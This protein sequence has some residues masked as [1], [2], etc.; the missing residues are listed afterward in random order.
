MTFTG[1]ISDIN[2]ALGTVTYKPDAN[3]NGTDAITLAVNDQGNTGSGGALSDSD[4]ANITVTAVNDAPTIS[5]IGDQ[6]IAEDGTTGALAFSVSD[7][8]TAAG[9]LTVTASSSNTTI[10]P[11][12]NLTLVDLGSGNWTIEASPALNQNGGPVTVTVDDGT[13]TTDETFDVTVTAVN[14]ASQAMNLS[15]A[16]SYTEDTA[17]NLIDIVASDVDSASV[18]ATLMLSNVAAG[19][20]N[21]G[22]SGVVTSTYNAGT[23]VW[24]ASGAIAD[25]NM[26]LAGLTFTPTLNFNSNF[27]IATSVSDG[28]LSVTGSKSMTG[29]AVNDAPVITSNGGGA[30]AA[31]NIAENTAAVTTVTSS[32]IDRGTPVYSISGGADAAKFAINS[33]SGVLTFISAPDY[34]TPTDIGADNVY[35]VTVQVSDGS[36][37][38]TQAIAVTITPVN[39]NSPVITSDGGGATASFNVAENST[40]VTTVTATDADLPAQALTYSISGGPDAAQFVVN[41]STGVL[42]FV[43]ARDFETPADADFN[44]V[45]VVTITVDDG[46]TGTVMQTLSVTIT[47]VNEFPVSAIGDSD[48]TTDAVAENQP[49]GTVVGVTSFA[50]DSDGTDSVSYSLDDNASGLFAIHA[51]T[52]VVTTTATLDAETSLSYSI[53]VRATSTDI[54]FSTRSFT[55]AVND[56]DEFD[57]TPPLDTDAAPNSVDETAANGTVVRITGQ[58]NDADATTNSVSYSLTDNAGGRFAIHATTGVVTVADGSPLNR[59]ASASHDITI[60][61]D[62]PLGARIL[63]VADAFDSMTND[64][65][66][67]KALSTAEACQELRSR[68]GSQFDPD[69]VERLLTVVARQQAVPCEVTTVSKETA[70]YIGSQME[71]LA[72]ALDDQDMQGLK[73]LADRLKET[74]SRN[75]VETISQKANELEQAVSGDAELMD[76]LES[77]YELVELC[78]STQRAYIDSSAR[79][80]ELTATP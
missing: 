73:V 80:C 20:L 30:N 23:G 48:R 59:E 51:T 18:T 14:D 50:S 42:S 46:L 41:N 55:I 15:A 67:R 27:T 37:T 53:T 6:T 7:V 56:I 54:S 19:S 3:F 49:A 16:E 65:I 32:D 22:T 25:V 79:P 29:T 1:S 2:T 40:A 60:R 38:D 68:A 21:T 11:N 12:G 13:T 31:I 62:I 36:L 9:S 76:V 69:L 35:D 75:G 5:A 71:R 72:V 10:I 24:S 44:N 78:R 66:Y 39:D 4:S 43:L 17:L 77:A 47:D 58:S 74:A 8:E 45:Y 26:L 52:G 64:S 61:A 28:S 70:I 33:S 34:E 57:V 63:A